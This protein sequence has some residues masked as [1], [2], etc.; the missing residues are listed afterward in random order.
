MILLCLELPSIRKKYISVVT[1][2]DSNVWICTAGA[3]LWIY[4]A[5]P[6]ATRQPR[7]RATWGEGDKQQIYTLLNIT[8]TSSV[9]ILTRKGLYVFDSILGT[10][11]PPTMPPIEISPRKFIPKKYDLDLN[12]GVVIESGDNLKMLTTDNWF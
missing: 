3:G 7:A 10:L 5:S 11:P 1:V 12:E 2:V 4:D 6:S 9:L 8:E